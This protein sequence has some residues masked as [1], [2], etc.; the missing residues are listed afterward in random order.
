MP[1]D[2]IREGAAC[3]TL[4]LSCLQKTNR[5]LTGIQIEFLD[6]FS[7][8]SL[9][10]NMFKIFELTVIEIFL[11]FFQILVNIKSGSTFYSL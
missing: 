8:L 10:K 3:R 2:V 11:Y 6:P 7:P 1:S 4:V 9:C 5:L